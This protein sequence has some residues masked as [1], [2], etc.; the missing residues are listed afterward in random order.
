MSVSVDKN[1][2]SLG[3]LVM[4]GMLVGVMLIPNSASMFDG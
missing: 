3:S 1:R 4:G 2:G